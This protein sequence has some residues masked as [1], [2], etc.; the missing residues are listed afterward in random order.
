MSYKRSL[1]RLLPGKRT[2]LRTLLVGVSLFAAGAVLG[3][4]A[5]T[6]V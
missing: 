3:F 2:V 5:I 6:S 4:I 1:P